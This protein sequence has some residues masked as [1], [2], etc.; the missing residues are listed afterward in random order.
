MLTVNVVGV[1]AATT[2]ESL[3]DALCAGLPASL[4]ATVK[5]PVPVAVGVPEI[6]P[7]D[8]DRLSPAG[9][10][11]LE[12]DQVYGVVPPIACVMFE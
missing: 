3:T 1:G 11:P 8:E 9:R 2:I 5:M 7:V 10:L 6:R 4:T 12:I